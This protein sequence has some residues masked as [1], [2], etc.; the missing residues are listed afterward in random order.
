MMMMMIYKF[1]N[2]IIIN[3]QNYLYRQKEFITTKIVI[4]IYIY[5]YIYML[6]DVSYIDQEYLNVRS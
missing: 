2:S 5:I 4:Y 1:D 6:C 3:I